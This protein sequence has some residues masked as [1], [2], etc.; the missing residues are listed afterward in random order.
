M[1]HCGKILVFFLLAL[2]KL[3]ITHRVKFENSLKSKIFLKEYI[4]LLKIYTLPIK[5]N[6]QQFLLQIFIRIYLRSLEYL[7][8]NVNCR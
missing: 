2:G 4:L 5:I 8:H 6:R 3:V 1:K 7:G